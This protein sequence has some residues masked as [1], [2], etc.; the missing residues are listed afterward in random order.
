MSGDRIQLAMTTDWWVTRRD[1]PPVRDALVQA[2]LRHWLPVVQSALAENREAG[3]RPATWE[4]L[5]DAMDRNFA[6]L[7]R[8]RKGKVRVAWYD[9][10]L[11]AEC[12]GLR[13][14]QLTPTRRQWLPAATQLLCGN[15]ISSCEAEAYASYRMTGVRSFNPHLDPAALDTVL[16]RL[17]DYARRQELADAVLRTAERVGQVLMESEP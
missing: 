16:Q 12:L 3:R 4:Q 8:A 11:M 1:A 2:F 5:A 17:P 7:W 10:Q 15:S 14:E 6:T 9:A 13:I